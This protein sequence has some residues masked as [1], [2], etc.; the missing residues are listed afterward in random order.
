MIN[1]FRLEKEILIRIISDVI[2]ICMSANQAMVHVQQ[3]AT[4]KPKRVLR[5]TFQHVQRHLV[6]I[7]LSACASENFRDLENVLR[8]FIYFSEKKVWLN[9]IGKAIIP[10]SQLVITT[11]HHH[12]FAL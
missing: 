8:N 10:R 1:L 3:T 6:G 2:L 5:F 12:S 7:L 11:T 9:V 4:V